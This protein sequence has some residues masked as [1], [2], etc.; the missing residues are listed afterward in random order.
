MKPET[1]K[2][3]LKS[4]ISVKNVQMLD[5]DDLKLIKIA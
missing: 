5:Q 2:N 3:N 1:S 4:S